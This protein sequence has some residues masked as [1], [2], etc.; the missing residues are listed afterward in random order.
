MNPIILKDELK[1][2]NTCSL[3]SYYI[4]YNKN[5][6]AMENIFLI[7]KIVISIN[8]KIFYIILYNHFKVKK[9]LDDWIKN[10]ILLFFYILKLTT[11]KII[12]EPNILNK[13]IVT[14]NS[15]STDMF[16]T[17]KL[18]IKKNSTFNFLTS[19]IY[20]SKVKF[21]YTLNQNIC[22]FSNTSK[23]LKG[24]TFIYRMQF[25]FSTF[26]EVASYISKNKKLDIKNESEK[27]KF[28]FDL[29]IN[30]F[31]LKYSKNL[32]NIILVI[33]NYII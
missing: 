8:F 27:L 10:K 31:L 32:K 24:E 18:N 2:A 16:S 21:K 5:M 11:F 22:I 23:N 6:I 20:R 26:S 3:N 7:K 13:N 12:S 25:F 1:N 28:I 14:E 17:I 15:D 33:L 29:Y 4:N 30:Y 9:D 19:L